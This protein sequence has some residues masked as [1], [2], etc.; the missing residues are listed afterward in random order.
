VYIGV[1]TNTGRAERQLRLAGKPI[2]Q[3][4]TVVRCYSPPRDEEARL[5]TRAFRD[6]PA[7]KVIAPRRLPGFRPPGRGRLTDQEVDLL[8]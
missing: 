2:E 7:K 6:R 1:P 8:Q 3:W 4:P 5:G